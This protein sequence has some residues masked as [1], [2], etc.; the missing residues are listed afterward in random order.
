MVSKSVHRIAWL[1][2]IE[3]KIT[4]EIL[5]YGQVLDRQILELYPATPGADLFPG[6]F[7]HFIVIY[8]SALNLV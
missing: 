6:A 3:S 8:N 1:S 7:R 5:E 2:F 4:D